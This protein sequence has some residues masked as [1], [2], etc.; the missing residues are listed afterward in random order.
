MKVQT[1]FS[2]LEAAKL[3]ASVPVIKG[4][5]QGMVPLTKEGFRALML[6]RQPTAPAPVTVIHKE[7]L[8]DLIASQA[9]DLAREKEI[10][11]ELLDGDTD[12]LD[13]PQPSRW[14]AEE[15]EDGHGFARGQDPTKALYDQFS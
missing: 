12:H 1:L 3:A 13:R 8:A 4:R 10:G 2:F 15:T 6:R 11:V 9:E 5:P 14:L 7:E